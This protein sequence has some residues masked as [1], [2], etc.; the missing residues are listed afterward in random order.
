MSLHYLFRM[1]SMKSVVKMM[2]LGK[3][4][5]PPED[6]DRVSTGSRGS[7]EDTGMITT[8]YPAKTYHL[9]IQLKVPAV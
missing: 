3:Q 2:K 1:K 9:Y 6:E 7:Y 8:V 5:P 4:R